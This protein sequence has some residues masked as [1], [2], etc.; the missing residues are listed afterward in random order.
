MKKLLIT[1]ASGFLGWN[2]CSIASNYFKVSA[3]EATEI[4]LICHP[5][6]SVNV[7]LPIISN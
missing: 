3:I 7:I 5:F 6:Q 2:L 4:S 1:G